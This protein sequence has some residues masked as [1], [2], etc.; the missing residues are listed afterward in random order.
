MP[1]KTKSREI[2]EYFSPLSFSP[3]PYLNYTSFIYCAGAQ[4]KPT[5]MLMGLLVLQAGWPDHKC[6]MSSQKPILH[7]SISASTNHISL[8]P[9]KDEVVKFKI[10]GLADTFPST[11]KFSCTQPSR[12]LYY[13]FFFN[14]YKSYL[15]GPDR[16]RESRCYCIIF[17]SLGNQAKN[18]NGD[19]KVDS[20]LSIRRTEQEDTLAFLPEEIARTNISFNLK[21]RLCSVAVCPDTVRK[22]H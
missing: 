19:S 6:K 4:R 7:L 8:L 5:S 9:R 13:Y 12:F 22:G 10:T 15:G 20:A 2:S 17:I 11:F 21:N 14:T 1:R 18:L 3:A 16:Q